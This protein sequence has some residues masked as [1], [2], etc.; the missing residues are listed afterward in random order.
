MIPISKI[1][2]GDMFQNPMLK[3]W[4][5]YYFVEEVDIKEKM[6]KV[7]PINPKTAEHIGKP[8]WKSNKDR[9]FS[10]SWR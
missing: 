7:Q 2:R 10:E 1:K 5:L 9:M 6:V 4:G 3:P 8:I